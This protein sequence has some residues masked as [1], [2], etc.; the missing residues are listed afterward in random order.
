MKDL[1]EKNKKEVLNIIKN[2]RKITLPNFGNVTFSEKEN[3]RDLVTKF[4]ILVEKYLLENLRTIF[5]EVGFVGEETGGDR[6]QEKFWL[7]DPIDGTGHFIRGIAHCSTMVSLINEGSVIF[8]VIYDFVNNDMYYAIK[9]KGAYKNDQKIS[10]S[11]RTEKQAV[12]GWEVKKQTNKGVKIRSY[13]EDNFGYYNSLCAGMPF[14]L[15]AEGKIDGLVFFDPFGNDY[16]FAA[17]SLLVAEADGFVENIYNNGYD[18]TNRDF[19]ASNKNIGENLKKDI[20][21]I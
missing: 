6:T 14:A 15:V 19:I 1:I 17:G 12:L 20:N 11:N 7:V 16:D 13:L 8:S 21:Q 4:D 9:G 18:Y 5:P 3:P 2:T 10:V